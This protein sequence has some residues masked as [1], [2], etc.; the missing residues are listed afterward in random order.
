MIFDGEKIYEFMRERNRT[1]QPRQ[2]GEKPMKLK[3][4]A[5]ITGILYQTL[6]MIAN[7]GAN[8]G[9]LKSSPNVENAM[10]IVRAL[11]KEFDDFMV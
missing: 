2:R 3:D 9:V 11:G 5:E 1:G 4:L 10:K 6:W 8:G 7:T